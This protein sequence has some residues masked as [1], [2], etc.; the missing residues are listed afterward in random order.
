MSR[1]SGVGGRIGY[2]LG[3]S[4]V[5]ILFL[6]VRQDRPSLFSGPLSSYKMG[7]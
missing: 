6:G 2:G 4:G 7:I 3:G 1:D 5:T